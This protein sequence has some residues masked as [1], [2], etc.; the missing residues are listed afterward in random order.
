MRPEIDP[1]PEWVARLSDCSPEEASAA[2]T[3][4]REQRGLF[5][6]LAA[7]HGREGRSSYIEIDAPLELHAIARLLR[8][9]HV[10]EVGVASGVSTAYLLHA[11]KMNGRGTL[12]SV[13]RPSF[14]RRNPSRG[15]SAAASWSLPPDRTSGWAVPS[16]LTSRWDLRLGDKSVLLPVL[17]KELPRVDLFLYDVPHD[18][19]T[20]IV[21]FRALDPVFREGAVA[22]V[23]HGPHGDRC[24]ALAAWGRS[25]HTRLW[26]RRV[27][28]LYGMRRPS[29]QPRRSIS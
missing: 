24:A 4:A 17:A 15:R 28:G 11:L 25:A 7:E 23:D 9:L 27:L 20:S 14:R 16:G 13:D 26:R 18:D 5:D 19:R 6:H 3:E 29:E 8:P 1:D 2:V 10:V 22:I 12:H 21:E